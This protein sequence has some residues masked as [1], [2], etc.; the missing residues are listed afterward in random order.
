MPM[1]SPGARSESSSPADWW[2]CPPGVLE[3]VWPHA[4]VH[5]KRA[6]C[7][8]LTLDDM[9]GAVLAGA[10]VLWIATIG[11]EVVGAVVAETVE[12]TS[13]LRVARVVA[14]GGTRIHEWKGMIGDI[15]AW[16]RHNGCHEVEIV[17]RAGWGRLYASRGFQE[18][19]RSFVKEL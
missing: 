10:A 16:A 1:E 3:G 12:Y 19:S 4:A 11:V 18:L 7:G 14:C 15:E 6:E 5:L 9:R 17:G 2:I 8:R 13:G